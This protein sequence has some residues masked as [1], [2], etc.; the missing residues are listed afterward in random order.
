MITEA[1]TLFNG[2]DTGVI[3]V[4]LKFNLYSDSNGT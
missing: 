4:G 1:H 2:L 3:N